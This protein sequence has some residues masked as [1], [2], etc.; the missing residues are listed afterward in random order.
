[1]IVSDE[2]F[3]V[4]ATKEPAHYFCMKKDEKEKE[5]EIDS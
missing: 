5:L 3:V 1:M 2:P 4:F